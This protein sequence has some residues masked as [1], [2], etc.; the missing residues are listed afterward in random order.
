[1]DL[2][3]NSI[4]DNP[5]QPGISAQQY[6]PDQLIVDAKNLVSDG[7]A[8]ITGL[9]ALLRG[10][11]MGQVTDGSVGTQ[12]G[13]PATGTLTFSAQPAAGNTIVLNGTT[14]TW[15]AHGAAPTSAQVNIGNTVAE[16]MENLL[17]YLRASADTQL[18]KFLY[19]AAGLVITLTAATGGTGGN[20]LTTVTTGTAVTAGGA[21][22]AGGASNTGNGTFGAF[23]FGP[24]AK[25]GAYRL[26][27]NQATT[28]TPAATSQ[29]EAGNVGTGVMGT[30]TPSAGSQLG[31]YDVIL[32][33]TGATAAFKVVAP[34]GTIAG[35]GNVASAYA[36][37]GLAFT[38]ANGGTMTAGDAWHIF[39]TDNG[40]S[41]FTMRDP[42]GEVRPNGTVGTAYSDQL[43]FTLTNGATKFI[44][45]DNFTLTVNMA[46]GK[47]CVSVA[48]ATDGSQ[49]PSGI[50]ADDSDPSAGDVNGGVYIAGEFNDRRVWFDPS[51][52]VAALTPRLRRYSIY[53]KP[54][55]SAEPPL[56]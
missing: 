43:K 42:D 38:L 1:M 26:T 34:D 28:G 16:S 4:G 8:T 41:T 51:W 19:T 2:L 9:A 48:T 31:Q 40:V 22:L 7:N 3:V 6:I 29:P 11:V 21:T 36:T 14:V 27:I 44:V 17:A 13:T 52:T 23:T 46:T 50:L 15:V 33:A 39:V 49:N 47:W 10:T 53:L 12:A 55:I 20:S 45:G 32:T 37:G 30:V 5:F 56:T 35:T 24:G 25:L 54:S 18:V